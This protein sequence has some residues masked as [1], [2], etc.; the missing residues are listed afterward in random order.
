MES[1][2]FALNAVAPVVFMVFIGYFLKR[3]G[4]LPTTLVAPLNKL[5][6]RIL[7][8]V[9]LFSNV[10]QIQSIQE[11]EFGY[12]LY[13]LIFTT[14]FFLLS[15]PVVIRLTQFSE[16]RSVI[17][18]AIFRSNFA[19]IGVAFAQSLYGEIGMQVASLLSAFV[20]P[21]YNILGVFSLSVFSEDKANK[22]WKSV[23]INILKNPLIIGIVLGLA[24]LGVRFL[25]QQN[26]IAF[27]LTDIKPIYKVI[28]HL[29]SM[30]TPL[31]LLVLGAG[32]EFSAVRDRK[33]EILGGVLLRSVMV[34]VLGLGTAYFFFRG[35]FNGAHFAVFISSFCTPVAVSTVPMAQEMNGDLPLASQ[36]VVWTTILSAFLVFLA[37]YFLRAAGVL[38]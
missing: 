12:I 4:L 6:F 17:L 33:K 9:M 34:P 21:L 15:I 11:I 29:S 10:Y 27:R 22:N 37:A 36:L 26:D 16:R 7:L 31:A 18:H 20:I 19:L 32:F 1:F 30:A 13:V 28:D 8:P 14:G 2:L 38:I 24:T 23:F 3:I 5:N 35:H 25:F